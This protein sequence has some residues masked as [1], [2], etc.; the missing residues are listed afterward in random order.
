MNVERLLPQVTLASR[1]LP[2]S[3]DFP[4]QA[5]QIE[6]SRHRVVIDTL[7]Q[8]ADMLPFAE[9]TLVVYTHA[10][11]DHCW[12]TGAFPGRPV[13]AHRLTRERLLE[14]GEATLQR[15]QKKL[16]EEFRES[17]VV[18][19]DITFEERLCID[20]GGLSVDLHH[21]PGHTADSVVAHIPE[22][23]LLVAGDAVEAP[24]PSLNWVGHIRHWARELRRWAEAGPRHVVPSH[25][26]PGGVELLRLNADYIE[27]LVDK[28][29][30]F[31]GAGVPLEEIVQR[32]PLA[33]CVPAAGDLPDYYA[34]THQQ[35]IRAVFA[36]LKGL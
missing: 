24:L 2:G 23:G 29:E 10:D 1:M 11:W 9:A 21:L 20:A 25:G 35:N 15:W 32:I 12:G 36:E 16:P 14:S 26:K 22:L 31:L 19:P 8:P 18:L 30:R 28:T 6:G 34:S 3:Y 5:A 33:D 13:I 27:Y 17:R 7:I 4:V